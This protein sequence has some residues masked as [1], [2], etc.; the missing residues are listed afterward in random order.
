MTLPPAVARQYLKAM[1]IESWVPRDAVPTIENNTAVEIPS[2]QLSSAEQK[3]TS[4][5]AAVC[6]SSVD[7]FLQNLAE[8][9]V[10]TINVLDARIVLLL[11]APILEPAGQQLLNSML[12]AIDINFS[13][14]GFGY[15][16]SKEP[17]AGNVRSFVGNVQPSII[18]VMANFIHSI[19]DLAEHRA[20]LLRLPWIHAPVAITMHPN[21]LMDNPA[22]K[23][24]AWED[25]KRVKASLDG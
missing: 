12:N 21:I 2:P 6:Q 13:E 19:D 23:R 20:G 5:A 25:L 3:V 24:P 15:L 17:V 9:P 7:T 14:Q 22:L 8:Q 16:G 1:G 18:I 10:Q 4:A 11:E